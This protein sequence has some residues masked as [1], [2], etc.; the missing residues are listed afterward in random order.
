MNKLILYLLVLLYITYVSAGYGCP[1]NSGQCSDYC[2]LNAVS[3]NGM[4]SKG[5]HCYF[6]TCVCEY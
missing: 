1:F 5:G 2:T 3:P 4:R 6:T